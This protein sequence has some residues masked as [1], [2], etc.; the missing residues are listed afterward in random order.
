[1][2][3]CEQSALV[4]VSTGYR[5]VV[6]GK[7]GRHPRLGR[8][9]AGVFAPEE[10]LDVLAKALEFMMEHYRYGRNLGTIIEVVGDPW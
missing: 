3:V 6:G 4:P 2:Q 1:M 7:L 5:V 9:L 10:A 8:E